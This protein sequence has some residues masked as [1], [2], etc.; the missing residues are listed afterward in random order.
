MIVLKP[1]QSLGGL[2]Q[3]WKCETHIKLEGFE[4]CEYDR[5][6]AFPNETRS[7]LQELIG[8]REKGCIYA[9]SEAAHN[10][11]PDRHIWKNEVT[12]D[13]TRE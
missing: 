10:P 8:N 13:Q 4:R 2:S 5:M 11:N 12:D 9:K 6:L 3:E 7:R 1:K